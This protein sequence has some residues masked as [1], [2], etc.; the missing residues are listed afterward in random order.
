LTALRDIDERKT[1]DESRAM[2][3]MWSIAR[4]KDVKYE[5]YCKLSRQAGDVEP[6]TSM[7]PEEENWVRY[8]MDINERARLASLG[9]PRL[10]W[11]ETTKRKLDQYDMDR[12]QVMEEAA[13]RLEHDTQTLS[14]ADYIRL[15][16]ERQKEDGDDYA[17]E[18][19]PTGMT[20]DEEKGAMDSLSRVDATNYSSAMV[21][22][23]DAASNWQR[24]SHEAVARYRARQNGRAEILQ[25]QHRR[26][27]EADAK[28]I[29]EAPVKELS[30]PVRELSLPATMPAGYLD[31]TN[32]L[33]PDDWEGQTTEPY[34][35][36]PNPSWP[37][38]EY[39]SPSPSR[40]Q[41]LRQFGQLL[42]GARPHQDSSNG[43]SR[44]GRL[45]RRAVGE[46]GT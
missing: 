8:G 21:F 7:A 15:I 16:Q 32:S 13:R 12:C 14:N 30:F 39:S 34:V 17:F 45:D 26:L 19:T 3:D 1:V 2:Y 33:N 31:T 29:K 20:R 42:F 24:D 38:S 28:K 11:E 43:Q 23:K 27:C 36:D 46:K 37:P 25:A 4:D 10:C 18:P 5:I 44:D 41:R 6:V 40:L 22:S 35:P 9:D